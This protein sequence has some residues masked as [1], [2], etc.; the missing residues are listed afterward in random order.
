MSFLHTYLISPPFKRYPAKPFF[1]PFPFQFIFLT[2]SVLN[3]KE[4]ILLTLNMTFSPPM[5]D[6]DCS[7]KDYDY[8]QSLC[9]LN[10]EKREKA[11][12]CKLECMFHTFNIAYN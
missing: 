7:C 4:R 9:Q 3:K 12:T 6:R 2:M 8:N 5:F 10:L 1:S 11:N